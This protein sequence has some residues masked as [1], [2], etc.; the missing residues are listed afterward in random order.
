M[1][2]EALRWDHPLLACEAWAY[3]Y[4]YWNHWVQASVDAGDEMQAPI[5]TSIETFLPVL[6]SVVSPTL[7]GDEMQA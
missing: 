1:S 2:L 3:I 4:V 7:A 5:E 6:S